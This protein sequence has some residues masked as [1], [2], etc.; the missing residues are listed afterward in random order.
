[1]RGKGCDGGMRMGIMNAKYIGSAGIYS[2]IGY[3][4]DQI[5]FQIWDNGY[6]GR[7]INGQSFNVH[8]NEVRW[9]IGDRVRLNFDCKGRRCTVF[10]NDQLLEILTDDLPENFFLAIS[11]FWWN[12]ELETTL[13]Q[14]W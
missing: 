13:F 3:A 7:A 14:G 12:T 8:D 9:R 10:L 1:M 4:R 6:P 11:L 5:A 2:A